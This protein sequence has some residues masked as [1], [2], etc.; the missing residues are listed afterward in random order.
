MKFN[1]CLSRF[2]GLTVVTL[3]GCAVGPSQ[4]MQ[5]TAEIVHTSDKSAES[6]ARCI[7][8]GWED[9]RMINIGGNPII[10][11]K[12][13]DSGLRVTKRIGDVVHIIALVSTKGAGSR[14]Q[15]WTQKLI[16]GKT[17]F[18]VISICQ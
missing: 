7:D 18:D 10:D 17:Y 14:T 6:V 16:G 3:A 1:S 8:K 11:T 12:A 4:L 5:S 2:I 9:M 13:T 15:I